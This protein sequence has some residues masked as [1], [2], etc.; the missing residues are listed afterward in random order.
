[1]KCPRCETSMLDERPRD[2]ITIDVCTQCR[3]IWLDRGEL[4]RLIARARDEEESCQ[5]ERYRHRD[6]DHHYDYQ[7]HGDREHHS[8]YH[9]RHG[10]KRRWFEFLGD[11]F[12]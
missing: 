4:E 7:G 10:R 12:D 1:M 2:G 5:Q 11:V 9:E 3:G 6:D 8:K